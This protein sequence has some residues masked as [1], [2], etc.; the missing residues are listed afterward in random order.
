MWGV[1]AIRLSVYLSV[2]LNLSVR[3]AYGGPRSPIGTVTHVG[4]ESRVHGEP[5]RDGRVGDTE[6]TG[7]SRIARRG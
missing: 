5:R 3:R 4:V 1:A 7:F 2:V 6:A